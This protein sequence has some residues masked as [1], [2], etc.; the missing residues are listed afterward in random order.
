MPNPVTVGH[1][2][3]RY[4][5]T[6]SPTQQVNVEAYLADIWSMV[7]SRRPLIETYMTDETVPA[8]EVVRVVANAVVRK[9]IN[10][11]G[12]T[13]ESIDDYRF[14]YGGDRLGELYLSPDDLIDLTPPTV[15]T[16]SRNSVRLV[17]YGES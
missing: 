12:K 4:P 10:P 8:S 16:G 5:G 17:A 7:M 6:L 1:V 14:T 13:M 3:A 2:M 11:E 9:L 15:G